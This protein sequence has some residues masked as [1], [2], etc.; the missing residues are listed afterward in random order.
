M[1]IAQSLIVKYI[2]KNFVPGSVR[3]CLM[4]DDI[5]KITDVHGAA[6]S[7]TINLYGDILEAETKKLVA[8]GNVDHNLA[9]LGIKL[10]TDWHDVIDWQ[11]FERD[12]EKRIQE[13]KRCK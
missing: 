12:Q 3:I 1:T 6:L 9:T 10:P 7:F 2:N 8:V 4:D 11:L 5:V 13:S